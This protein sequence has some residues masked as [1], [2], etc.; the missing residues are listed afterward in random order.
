MNDS[1]L[2][3]APYVAAATALH[4]L[5]LG[6][7]RRAEVERQFRLLTTLAQ[8]VMDV[9]LPADIEPAETYRP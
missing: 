2:E 8:Q 7:V 3:V 5:V 6:E 9:A 1:E 4:G